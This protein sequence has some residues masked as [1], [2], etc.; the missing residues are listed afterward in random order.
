MA[1]ETS[2]YA[3]GPHNCLLPGSDAWRCAAVLKLSVG[4]LLWRLLSRFDAAAAAA[5][6]EAAGVGGAAAP[7]ERLALWSAHDAT[8]HA[9]LAAVGAPAREWAPYSADLAFELWRG[10]G[11]GEW[12]RILYLGRPLAAL[13]PRGG[14][15]GGEKAGGDSG[16]EGGWVTLE[17]LR[18]L[19]APLVIT[20]E[21]KWRQCWPDAWPF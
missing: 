11:G 17:G 8:L 21:D 15:G 6:A 18:E 9:L 20:D 4:P 13:T 14:G 10:E 7:P 19:V 3:P 5:E 2:I 1:Y 12:V 16:G